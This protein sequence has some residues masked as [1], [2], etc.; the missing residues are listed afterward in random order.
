MANWLPM[1]LTGE[2]RAWLLNLPGSTVA[3]WEELRGLFDA[4]FAAPAP[5]AIAAL[6]SGSQ[7]PPSVRYTKPFF[8]QIGAASTQQGALLGWAAPKADLTFNSDDHPTNTAC[9]GALPMLCTL[10]I[11]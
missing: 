1:A 7:A 8:R 2:P 11:C 6:L 3:S 10:T 5:L 4:R 9:S